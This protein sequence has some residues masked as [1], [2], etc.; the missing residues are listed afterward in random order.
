MTTNLF[1]E[2]VDVVFAGVQSR[3]ADALNLDKS[4]VSRICSG[5]R[6]VTPDIALLIEKISDGR[7]R[8]ESFIWPESSKAAQ[9][10][11]TNPKENS[12]VA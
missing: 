11:T 12:H 1:N 3:A 7:Y 6:S 4:T 8:K 10:T 5:D 2:F 9:M